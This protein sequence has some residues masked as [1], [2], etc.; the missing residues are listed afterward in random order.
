MLLEHAGLGAGVDLAR[1]HVPDSFE[2][3]DW[4][5]VYPSYGFL[6]VCGEEAKQTALRRF[7][8]RGIWADGIG[9]TNGSGVLHLIWKGEEE[10]LFD[11]ARHPILD[12]PR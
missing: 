9:S 8:E 4:L 10:V 7:A 3:L 12:L 5:R 11:F 1:I 2:L 6:L